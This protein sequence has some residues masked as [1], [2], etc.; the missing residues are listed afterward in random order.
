[1]N[2]FAKIQV[3]LIM[4]RSECILNSEMNSLFPISSTCTIKLTSKYI[5]ITTHKGR[6]NLNE[7]DGKVNS[8]N[9][10]FEKILLPLTSN[11]KGVILLTSL[12]R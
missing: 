9:L 10:K 6:Y 11:S 1:M 12:T 8:R 7:R 3:T 5:T 4:T 2:K